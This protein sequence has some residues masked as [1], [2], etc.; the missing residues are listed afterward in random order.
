MSL[1]QFH[2]LFIVMA[3]ALTLAFAWWALEAYRATSSAPFAWT[4]AGAA[5][6]AVA[7]IAYGV[8]FYRKLGKLDAAS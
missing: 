3:T 1:K 7:L 6:A 5:V 4:A 2:I 8:V